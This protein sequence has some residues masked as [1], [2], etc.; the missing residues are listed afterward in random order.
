MAEEAGKQAAA[1]V[2]AALEATEKA[3]KDLAKSV[4]DAVA[5]QNVGESVAQAIDATKKAGEEL[6]ASMES[7]LAGAA[8]KK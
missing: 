6:A 5:G 2:A 3:G 1:T 4:E 8:E 7:A